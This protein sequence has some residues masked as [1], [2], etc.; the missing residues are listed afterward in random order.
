MNCHQS[1]VGPCL[2]Q[3]ARWI[4]SN[5]FLSWTFCQEN[6]TPYPS[7]SL[8]VY[9]ERFDGHTCFD[10]DDVPFK[11]ETTPKLNGFHI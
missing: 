11:A 8:Y 1:F 2:I 4:V 7:L 10:W 6:S 5:N 9:L 3:A